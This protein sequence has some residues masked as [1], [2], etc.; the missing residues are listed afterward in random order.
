[1]PRLSEVQKR[2]RD[3]I[4]RGEGEQVFLNGIGAQSGGANRWG[5]FSDLSVDPSDG[6][7]FW[8]TGSYYRATG[9]AWSTRLGS[10]RFPTCV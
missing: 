3:A 8:Y 4:V 7:T 5:D 9:S 10:F 6:C 2:L 1:M